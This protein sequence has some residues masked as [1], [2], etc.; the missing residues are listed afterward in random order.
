LTYDIIKFEWNKDKNKLNQE[1]HGVSFEE[2]KGEK[3][4]VKVKVIAELICIPTLVTV[5]LGDPN[6]VTFKAAGGQK[7]YT[8]TAKAGVFVWVILFFLWKRTNLSLIVS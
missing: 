6:P 4:E 8:W 5:I 7:P 3:V 2:A 1:K